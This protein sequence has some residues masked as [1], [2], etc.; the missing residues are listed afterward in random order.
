MNSLTVPCIAEKA[1][2]FLF[3]EQNLISEDQMR[4]LT[5]ELNLDQEYMRSTLADNG[6]PLDLGQYT[7]GV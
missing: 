7:P 1:L 4:L 6:R 3:A 2:M 5:E